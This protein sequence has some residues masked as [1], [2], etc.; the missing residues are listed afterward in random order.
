[1]TEFN[2]FRILIGTIMLVLLIYVFTQINYSDLSFKTNKIEY[3]SILSGLC[4][5]LALYLSNKIETKKNKK[6]Q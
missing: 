5:I 6:T 3:I 2:K 1:M 4:T